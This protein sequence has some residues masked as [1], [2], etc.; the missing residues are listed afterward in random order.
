MV[1]PSLG[2]RTVNSKLWL[3][4][5]KPFQNSNGDGYKIRKPE[6]SRLPDWFIHQ[7]EQGITTLL[8]APYPDFC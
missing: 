4:L 7:Q 2:N 3:Y 1:S 6:L 8:S 5:P